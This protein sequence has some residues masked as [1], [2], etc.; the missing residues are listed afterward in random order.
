MSC[1]P[2]PNLTDDVK[3]YYGKTLQ[4]TGDLQTSMCT[5]PA[6]KM[7]KHV[8]EALKL[9]H[10]EVTSK[11]YGCG[12]VVPECLEGMK[13]LDLG[14][15][16]GRDCFALA[17]LV[18]PDGFVTGVDMTDEQLA[19]ANKHVEYHQKV[20]GFSKPNVKFVKGYIEK[21]GDAGIADE[22]VDII[23]SN[24]V[25][26][27][28][29]DKEAV[30]KEAYRV[31]KYGGELYFSDVYSDCIL[32]EEV[33]SHKVLWGECVSGALQWKQ[34]YDIAKS[35]GFETPRTLTVHPVEV[36]KPELKKVTGDAKFA[37]VL[38]RLFKLK[39]GFEN[40]AS[41]V[42]YNGSVTGFPDKLEFDRDYTFENGKAVTV[43]SVTSAILKQSRFADD[44]MMK[45]APCC[46][47]T[48]LVGEVDPFQIL[49]ES[50]EK[51]DMRSQACCTGTKCC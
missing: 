31:L 26:N 51:V 1:C 12:I 17:K 13:L 45:K 42:I 46:A 11:Y 44:F 33:R 19:V 40:E 18:G 24:C 49:E 23:I 30:L 35:V 32:S 39:P 27:L 7:A 50:G 48:T 38:Y 20:F 14:S 3:E 6:Q 34:L 2:A 29:K 21:L 43:D 5:T 4:T 15:G 8:R 22:S 37:S 10:D 25:I 9:V 41:Q 36:H 47:K 28:V 16:S